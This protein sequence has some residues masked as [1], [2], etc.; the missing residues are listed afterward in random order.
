MLSLAEVDKAIGALSPDLQTCEGREVLGLEASAAV[1]GAGRGLLAGRRRPEIAEAAKGDSDVDKVIA[2]VGN[3]KLLALEAAPAEGQRAAAAAGV[4]GRHDA[5]GDD[6]DA[7]TGVVGG[8]R[9]MWYWCK[10]AVVARCRG[11]AKRS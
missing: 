4:V 10:H 8:R 7:E 1:V 2:G 11:S 3:I 5:V 9:A 6:A